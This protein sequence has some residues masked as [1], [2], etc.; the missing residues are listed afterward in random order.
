VADFTRFSA[1]LWIEYAHEES[2]ILGRDLWR[3][4]REFRY[5]ISANSRIWVTIPR[6]YLID[7]ASVPRMLW[8]IIP[9]WGAY[10]A[11]T[12][13]HDLLCEYLSIVVDG[14]L[15]TISREYADQILAEAM[16]VLD[17]PCEDQ[18]KIN[19]AVAA[20]RIVTR[21]ESPVWHKNKA[22]LEAKWLINNPL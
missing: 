20:Y 14:Q 22:R 2:R 12:T 3:V 17:V 10:G 11:A 9:P 1:P 6:G 16:A 4:C 15:I 19:T 21:A 13:V 18:C 8:A 7:G 5:Y